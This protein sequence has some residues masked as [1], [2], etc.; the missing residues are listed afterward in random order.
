MFQPEE[1]MREE[2]YDT[3]QHR[4]DL[5][6]QVKEAAA[7]AEF[8]EAENGNRCRLSCIQQI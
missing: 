7:Q 6:E 8:D 4:V 5:R 2:F 3:E 1:T